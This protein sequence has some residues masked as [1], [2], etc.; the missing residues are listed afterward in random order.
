MTD[1]IPEWN[2]DEYAVPWR[3]PVL[4]RRLFY[5]RHLGASEIADLFG[6]SDMTIVRAMQKHDIGQPKIKRDVGVAVND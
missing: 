2:S 4:V 1:Q 6:V 5:Q 3:D